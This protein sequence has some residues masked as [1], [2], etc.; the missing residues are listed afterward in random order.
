MEL[1]SVEVESSIDEITPHLRWSNGILQQ[2]WNI[3]HYR[4]GVPHKR[5]TEWRDVPTVPRIP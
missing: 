4:G 2:A 3:T 5:S 1:K